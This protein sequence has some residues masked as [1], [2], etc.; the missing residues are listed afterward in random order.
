MA[1]L[2]LLLNISSSLARIEEEVVSKLG[3][4]HLKCSP[5]DVVDALVLFR[6]VF[7]DEH[8]DYSDK[9][10][11]GKQEPKGNTAGVYPGF[12]SMKHS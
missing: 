9:K 8:S 11:K 7:L 10:S 4:E 2:T 3:S 12:L 6:N 1:S 5:N